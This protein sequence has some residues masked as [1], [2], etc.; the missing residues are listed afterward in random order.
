MLLE[1]GGDP[2]APDASGLTAWHEAAGGG[3]CD[4]LDLF[5]AE[6]ILLP[7]ELPNAVGRHPLHMAAIFGH[8]PWVAQALT[9]YK[10]TLNVDVV[11]KEGCR[12]RACLL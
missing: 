5:A 7:Q 2:L 8:R 11:D 6:G 9:L 4:V 10:G 12:Y 1:A 3:H